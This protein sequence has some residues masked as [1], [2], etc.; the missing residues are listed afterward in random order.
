M[1]CLLHYRIHEVLA[2][3][4]TTFDPLSTLLVRDVVLGSTEE[5]GK[6]LEFLSVHLKSPKEQKL[7]KGVKVE[8]FETDS[9]ICPVR[10]IL[11][12]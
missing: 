11:D 4:Q 6:K 8:L 2:R 1:D 12:T 10:E 3:D 9:F 5:G 7:S